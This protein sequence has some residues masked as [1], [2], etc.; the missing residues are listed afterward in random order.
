MDNDSLPEIKQLISHIESS[1]FN[2][3]EKSLIID[4]I[5]K[6]LSNEQLMKLYN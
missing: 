6:L 2:E 4:H 3:S 5:I 1:N